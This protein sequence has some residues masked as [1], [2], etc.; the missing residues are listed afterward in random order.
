MRTYTVKENH[1]VSVVSKILR[2]RQTHRHR[3]CYFQS[4]YSGIFL[5]IHLSIF[6]GF[7]L[8]TYIYL[9]RETEVDLSAAS[10]AIIIV[11]SVKSPDYVKVNK[12]FIIF[13]TYFIEIDIKYNIINKR[14]NYNQY[15]NIDKSILSL[16]YVRAQIYWQ[17]NLY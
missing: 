11:S 16:F 10:C 15:F 5:S 2:Y 12:T 6:L 9:F 8:F 1:I 3:S 4:I 7:N 17:E 13:W 14:I